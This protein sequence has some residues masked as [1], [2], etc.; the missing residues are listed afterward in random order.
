[1][2]QPIIENSYLIEINIGAS[3]GQG[4]QTTIG[5]IL[6]LQGR[7]IYGVQAF[8]VDDMQLSPSGQAVVTTAGL[9]GL[10]LTLLENDTERQFLYPVS[11]LRSRNVSGFQRMFKPR[12]YELTRSYITILSTA[13]LTANQRL[14]LNFFYKDS[15]KG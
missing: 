2:L 6:P 4:L 5:T 13:S 3:L 12:M 1:M 15:V 8:S 10:T 14:C 11:D 9:A 7:V